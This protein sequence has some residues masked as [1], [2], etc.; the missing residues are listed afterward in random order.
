MMPSVV[1]SRSLPLKD[2]DPPILLGAAATDAARRYWWTRSGL[3]IRVTCL[4]FGRSLK[5]FAI[6]FLDQIDD[7]GFYV[8]P[9]PM[10]ISKIERSFT[11]PL[12]DRQLEIDKKNFLA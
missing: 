10:L 7:F 5:V 11:R 2:F 4:T 8:I 3:Q 6:C 1:N 12:E 9:Q